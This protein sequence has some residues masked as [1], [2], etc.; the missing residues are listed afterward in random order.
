MLQMVSRHPISEQSLI[1][2]MDI[3][4]PG[5][6]ARLLGKLWEDAVGGFKTPAENLDIDIEAVGKTT[7][8]EMCNLM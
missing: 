3:M 4:K 8:C 6:R 7:A 5:Y 1:N 2:D